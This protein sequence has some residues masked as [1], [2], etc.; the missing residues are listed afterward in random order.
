[1]Q[2]KFSHKIN[3]S[4]ENS[5]ETFQREILSVENKHTL[6]KTE[7]MNHRKIFTEE[8]DQEEEIKKNCPFPQ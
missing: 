2:G 5:G 6:L 4:A 3:R 8:K 1:M 7:E